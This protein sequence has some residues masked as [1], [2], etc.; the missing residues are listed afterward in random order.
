MHQFR[1]P[2]EARRWAVQGLWLMQASPPFAKTFP[3]A[4]EWSLEMASA[5]AGL[6][7]LGFVADVGRIALGGGSP[8]A[9]L[10]HD[11]APRAATGLEPGVA[12]EYEDYVLGRLYADL[13]FQRAADAI[14]HYQ[15]RDRSRAIAFLLTQMADR[16]GLP[17]VML[18][19]A[20][21][22][23]LLEEPAA[24]VLMEG[25]ESIRDEGLLPLLGQQQARLITA[26]RGTGDLLSGTDLFELERGTALA[27]FGQRLALP[28]AGHGQPDGTT[29][30]AP[31]TAGGP[32]AIFR[33]H[34]HGR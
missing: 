23:R 16:A 20:I 3:P 31:Q 7:P 4:L 25:W 15:G 10:P 18:S 24:D 33:G 27:E 30:P 26:I 32:P 12:R 28:G 2:D 5:G 8:A 34:P 6:P 17:G 11:E 19:P 13:T 22:K 1:D 21:L 29:A 9:A 14:L